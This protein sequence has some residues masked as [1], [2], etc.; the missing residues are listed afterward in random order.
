M[1]NTSTLGRAKGSRAGRW[2]IVALSG[3]FFAPGAASA[4]EESVLEG[5]WKAAERDLVIDVS[6]CG[7]QYCGQQVKPQN[8]CGATVLKLAFKTRAEDGILMFEGQLD[9]PGE[10]RS[11]AARLWVAKGT[12]KA[13]EVVTLEGDDPKAGFASREFPFEATLARSGAATCRP[14]VSS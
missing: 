6:R 1:G 5:R 2:L 9:L 3:A 12:D 13:S 10:G 8:Q 14:G 4:F 11:Y 7:A